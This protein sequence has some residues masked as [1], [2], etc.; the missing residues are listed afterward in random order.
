MFK[1]LLI[2]NRGEIAC[3]VMK[4]AKR[5]G[6]ATVAVYSEADRRARHVRLAGEALCIG[7]GPAKDSYLVVEKII[8]AALK[9]GAQAIHPGYGFLAENEA[10]CLA[11]AEAGLV[12]IGPPASAIRAMG[13][14]SEAR[15]LMERADV[16]LTPGYHGDDQDPVRLAREAAAIGYPVLIKAAAG[17]GGKGMRRVER[18]GDFAAELASCQREAAAA[19]GSAHVLIEKYILR[20]RHI[21]IQVFADSHGNV[22]HLF[23]RD[24]S[25]QRRHQKI[26]E[27]APA[28]GL[29]ETTRQAMGR[30]A[31]LVAKSAGYIGAGTV[32]FI[33]EED[34]A[35]YFMEMNT[36]LQVEHPVTEMITGLDLVEWQLRVAAGERLPLGQAELSFTGHAIEARVYAEDADKG[37]LPSTGKLVHVEFPQEGRHMRVDSGVE[38]GDAITPFYDPMIAKLIVWDKTRGAA[39]ERLQTALADVRIAGVTTN[40]DFLGRLCACTP[41]A[42]A[43]LDTGL[44]E[45]AHDELFPRKDAPPEEVIRLAALAEVLAQ[46]AEARER[47]AASAWVISDSWRL[48]GRPTRHL[49]LRH[50]DEIFTAHVTQEGEGYWIGLPGEE[51]YT[52]GSLDARGAL[53]AEYGLQHHRATI[54]RDGEV[55]HLFFAG[56]SWRLNVDPL[57]HSIGHAAGDIHLAAPMPGMIAAILAEA[58]CEVERNTPLLVLEAMKMQHTIRA[59]AKGIVRNFPFRAGDQVGEGVDL[60]DFEPSEEE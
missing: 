47:A 21:E 5:L 16:P 8:E 3:R 45:R 23:E 48:N 19:F 24:C 25:V 13:S 20:P 54:V 50:G 18:P 27:E 35:F 28:P 40:A 59:P 43:E 22:V 29:T 46:K 2:A 49:E 52:T 38:E 30:A 53:T 36:R 12:F 10:F 9:T 41:F 60:V 56:Q 58:G 42:R 6:I 32:E 33:V 15:K 34:G 1:K 39:R 57:H 26:L 7:P 31:I 55:R 17:G 14:K 37:F 11:C 51:L 4:T 44:I